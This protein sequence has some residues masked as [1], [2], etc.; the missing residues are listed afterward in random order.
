MSKQRK[1]TTYIRLHTWFSLCSL[2]YS[3]SN[4]IRRKE[5]QKQFSNNVKKKK[6][7]AFNSLQAV[8]TG[9]NENGLKATW[10]LKNRKMGSSITT[11]AKYKIYGNSFCFK[12]SYAFNMDRIY[13]MYCVYRKSYSHAGVWVYRYSQMLKYNVMSIA[14]QRKKCKKK[15]CFR[16]SQWK[17]ILFWYLCF[18][19]DR[20]NKYMHILSYLIDWAFIA[21]QNRT[22]HSLLYNYMI[23]LCF[24]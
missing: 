12:S 4:W 7:G 19:C 17:F 8:E 9:I 20:R 1:N 13:I 23:Q 16:C 22:S 24:I 11:T 3:R 10:I 21:L 18:D 6:Y 14:R 15:T 2:L 5:T